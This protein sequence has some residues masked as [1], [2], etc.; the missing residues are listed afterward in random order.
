MFSDS[1]LWP[2]SAHSNYVSHIIRGE[3]PIMP[4]NIPAAYWN[5]ITQ[6]W[7]DD[8]IVRPSFA[9]IKNLLKHDEYQNQV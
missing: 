3:R 1:Y 6:C 8:P 9:D 4:K 7:H 5:L 2:N